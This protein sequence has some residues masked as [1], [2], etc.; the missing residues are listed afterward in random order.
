[1]S[2]W[3]REPRVARLS[4][5]RAWLTRTGPQARRRVVLRFVL[6]RSA[7]VEFIVIRIAPDCRRVGRFRVAGRAGVNRI[8][9]RGRIR[10][11]VL[12]PG[13][14]RIRA[15][16]LPS[17]RALTETRLLIFSRTPRRDELVAARSSNTCRAEAAVADRARTTV[18]GATRSASARPSGRE[19]RHAQDAGPVDVTDDRSRGRGLGTGA[20]GVQF[21]RAADA[22]ERIHPLLFVLLGI[23]ITLLGLAS[24]PAHLVPSARVAAVLAYRRNEVALAGTAALISVAVA[25]ALV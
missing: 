23:A 14:Y 7:V 1:M 6:G 17:G 20:L 4:A 9:F 12:A 24:T 5:S 21:R 16:A 18:G 3:P 2:G 15:R 8:P 25:Y 22:V 13:T 10:G 11:H 19:G